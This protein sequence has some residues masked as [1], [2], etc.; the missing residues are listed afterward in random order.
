MLEV[1][2]NEALVLSHDVTPGQ[3][4]YFQGE[5]ETWRVGASLASAKLWHL[6]GIAKM[7]S[8]LTESLHQ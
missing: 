6:D 8:S 3:V 4:L 7:L 1:V 2:A 5:E